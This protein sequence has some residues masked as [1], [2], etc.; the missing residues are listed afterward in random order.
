MMAMRLMVGVLALA[1]IA[2]AL[3]VVYTQ[4]RSRLLFI[5]LQRLERE[6]AALNTEW[7]RLQLERSTW[8]TRAR[9][10][11]LARERLN[12]RGPDFK[13]ARIVVLP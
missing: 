2:S 5:E 8:A 7:G 9:I 11:R 13:R 10:E 1:V 4:H 6:H 12:M 3:G